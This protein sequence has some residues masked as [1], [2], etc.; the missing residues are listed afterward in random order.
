MVRKLFSFLTLV[1]FFL[2]SLSFTSCSNDDEPENGSLEYVEINGELYPVSPWV[3]MLGGDGGF[4]LAVDVEHNGIIDVEYFYFEY[5]GGN[6][7]EGENLAERDL[8]S[9]SGR[10]M[11]E[12]CNYT[13]KSGKAIVV[14]TDESSS[15]LTI[16]FENLI[17]EYGSETI[18]FNGTATFLFDF[19][20]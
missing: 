14:K 15:H 4:T 11:M 3:A 8:K 13:V 2:F 7:Q 6:P 1:F 17:M 12:E 20:L 10:G 19:E 18:T 16:R 5:D 9:S